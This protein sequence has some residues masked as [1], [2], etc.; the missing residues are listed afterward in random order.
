MA[1]GECVEIERDLLRRF[2][3][4]AL[5]RED[6]ILL[7]LFGSRIVEIVAEAIGDAQVGLLDVR[8]HL[9]VEFGR[10]ALVRRHRRVRVRVFRFQVGRD[11]G[12]ALLAQPKIVVD[13]RRS[14]DVRNVRDGLRDGRRRGGR[15]FGW[16]TRHRAYCVLSRC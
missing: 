13:A 4:A 2:D 11:S 8:Q 14:V 7:A 12:I 9:V 3:R 1:L 10:E 15:R 6:G 16:G 5:A